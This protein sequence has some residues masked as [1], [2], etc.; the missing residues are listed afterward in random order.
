MVNNSVK[1]TWRESR[2]VCAFVCVKQH[3]CFLSSHERSDSVPH[4]NKD[5]FPLIV[6]PVLSFQK[7]PL[8]LYISTSSIAVHGISLSNAFNSTLSG[9]LSFFL[10]AS[11]AF[12]PLLLGHRSPPT[13]PLVKGQRAEYIK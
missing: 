11:P 12:L 10:R 6:L 13:P 2:L 9:S 4:K 3:C 5:T 7:K 8:F 1:K